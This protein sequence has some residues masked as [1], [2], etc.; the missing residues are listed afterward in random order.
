MTVY[1]SSFAVLRRCRIFAITV[2]LFACAILAKG[3]PQTIRVAVL[4][5]GSSATG[6]RAADTIRQAF[7]ENGESAK[8]FVLI[9][10]DLAAAAARGSGFQGSLNLT[11][12]EAR[13][14]LCY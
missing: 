12:E 9:D 11:T 10:K 3:Q 14:R 4:D 2:A 8:G 6:A 7:R 13:Y 1:I 5:L